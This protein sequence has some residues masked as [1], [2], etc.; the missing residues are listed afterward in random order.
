MRVSVDLVRAAVSSGRL[1]AK[2]TAGTDPATG[3][4][5]PG[6]KILISSSALDAWFDAL[7]DA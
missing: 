2:Y 1:Q 3:K 4:R 5:R 7:E 6:G